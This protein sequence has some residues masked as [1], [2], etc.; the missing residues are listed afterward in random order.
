ML[1]ETKPVSRVILKNISF[2]KRYF[3]VEAKQ[4]GFID[5]KWFA[6]FWT[7]S[8]TPCCEFN[9]RICKESEH[10]PPRSQHLRDFRWCRIA[11]LDQIFERWCDDIG[12]TVP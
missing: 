8:G 2:L 12:N 10:L 3:W 4:H 5:K 6:V 9:V 1:L 11:T 7:A